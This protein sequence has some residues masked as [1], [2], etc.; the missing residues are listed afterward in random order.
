MHSHGMIVKGC[1][2]YGKQIIIHSQCHVQLSCTTDKHTHA[3]THS[4][5]H[6]PLLHVTIAIYEA[7]SR[8]VRSD[9]MIPCI[10]WCSKYNIVGL[11]VEQLNYCISILFISKEQMALMA[12]LKYLLTGIMSNWF[13]SLSHH[14][15]GAQRFSLRNN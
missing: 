13:G 7:S 3:R 2:R 9:L 4:H 6:K 15:L 12:K 14:S 10:T 5:T 1:V 11:R 8:F